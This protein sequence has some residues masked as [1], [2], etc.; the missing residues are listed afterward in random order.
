[1]NITIRK[2]TKEDLLQVHGLIME[3]AIYERA[4]DEVTN[5]LT[6]MQEDGFGEKPVYEFLVAEAEN[7]VVGL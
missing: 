3:L 7:K 1:M 6:D 2:G 5:T 4:P